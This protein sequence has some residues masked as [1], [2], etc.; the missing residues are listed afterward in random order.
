M[1]S[2]ASK[3]AQTSTVQEPQPPKVPKQKDAPLV[4]GVDLERGATGIAVLRLQRL[5]TRLGYENVPLNSKFDAATEKALKEFQERNKLETTGKYDDKVERVA[6]R[7]VKLLMN[8]LKQGKVAAP[9]RLSEQGAKGIRVSRLQRAL[10]KLGYKPGNVDGR[11][12][13]ETKAALMRFEK[14][15]RLREDGK[16][17]A[18]SRDM[19]AQALRGKK[20]PPPDMLG[21]DVPLYRQGDPRWGGR[22]LGDDSTISSAGCALTSTAMVLSKLSGRKIDPGELDRYL[23]RNHGYAGDAIEWSTAA[24]MIGGSAA[25][26]GWSFGTV[27]AN[28][29]AGRPVVIGID[30]KPGSG[31][32]SN[33]TDHWITLVG[34]VQEHGKTFYIANDPLTGTRIRLEQRDGRLFGPRNYKSTGQLRTFSR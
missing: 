3:V 23:D 26:P 22:I 16:Y 31:G 12:T 33:G 29:K 32:G 30:H 25:A 21:H 24:R 13:K 27:D 5:L 9:T 34:K 2:I 28:L 19:L 14:A 11:F 15:Y 1:T 8:G 7:R 20:P 17:D 6:K 10:Q 4:P 18:Q